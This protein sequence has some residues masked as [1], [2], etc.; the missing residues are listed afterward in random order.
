MVS[1]AILVALILALGV[2]LATALSSALK[3]IMIMAAARAI[4]GLQAPEV[5]ID[6]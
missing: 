6:G 4:F 3:W 5:E 2:P 1:D